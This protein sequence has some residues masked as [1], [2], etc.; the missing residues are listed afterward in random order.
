MV[1]GILFET[2]RMRLDLVVTHD[3]GRWRAASIDLD[4][5]LHG[6][7]WVDESGAVSFDPA[8][9]EVAAT[10]FEAG[11][12]PAPEAEVV[13]ELLPPLIEALVLARP[14]ARLPPALTPLAAGSIQVEGS[15]VT[16]QADAGEAP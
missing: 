1:D 7:L 8:A 15:Y 6:T 12:L 4:V 9:V 13:G 5:V 3:G 14:L 10:A 2:G 11:L 16:W